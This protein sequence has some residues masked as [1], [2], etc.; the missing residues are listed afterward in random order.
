V[1]A[2]RRG[3]PVYVLRASTV[4]QIENF[5]V[6]VFKLEAVETGDPFGIAMTEV[7]EAISRIQAGE[8]SVSLTPQTSHIRRQQHMA[9]R[10]AGIYSVSSGT[11]EE[12][13]VRLLRDDIA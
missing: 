1:D 6:D 9:A 2:E 11:S 8:E 4:S 13:F 3:M 5:L 7:K 10:E 12:R